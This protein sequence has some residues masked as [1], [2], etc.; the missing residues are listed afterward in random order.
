MAATEA[1]TP[2]KRTAER[3]VRIRH[4]AG[5]ILERYIRPRSLADI[6]H[7]PWL[8]SAS[9]KAVAGKHPI[10]LNWAILD[11]GA[12]ICLPRTPKCGTCRLAASCNFCL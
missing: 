1:C 9:R 11:F 8:Q 7:D 12:L 5:E 10:E 6:R 4:L 2:Y 3:A